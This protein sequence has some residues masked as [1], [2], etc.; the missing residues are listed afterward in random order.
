M[1]Q[2]PSVIWAD[3]L[4]PLFS[5]CTDAVVILLPAEPLISTGQLDLQSLNNLLSRVDFFE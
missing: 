3:S 5:L 1:L 2:Q 4:K